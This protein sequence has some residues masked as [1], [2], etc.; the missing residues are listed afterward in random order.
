MDDF[1]FRDALTGTDIEFDYSSGGITIC[2]NP[3]V[4]EQYESIFFPGCSFINYAMPLVS[5]VYKTLTDN[6]LV[7][8]ISVLCCGKILSYEENGTVKRDAFE[9]ELKEHIHKAGI[10]RIVCACPNC[11]KAMREAF[12]LDPRTKDVELAILPTVM[13]DCGYKVDSAITN[14]LM[15]GDESKMTRLCIHDSC[16]DR[17]Y[18]QFADGLRGILPK[19]IWVDPPHSRKR[20]IC[21][22]SLPRAQ[23]KIEQADKCANING[24]EAL[25]LNADA[26]VTA[27]MSCTFQ[28][29]MAQNKV[30]AVHFLELLYD[31]RIDWSTVGAWMKLRFLFD[32]H[33]GVNDITD[34]ARAFVS[35]G[36][37]DASCEVIDGLGKAID[38]NS[39]ILPENE[40]VSFSNDN[41]QTISE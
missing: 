5:A 21:C 32:E 27:C 29:N 33:L 11:V 17:E 39:A 20:S 4:T 13:T 3:D 41:V 1:K 19:D 22:G 9:E 30:P 15:K 7:D 24:T 37:S 35:I 23:G 6:D 36:E 16:P 25:E 34:S 26:L 28:L 2:R 10:K 14:R 8:G 38:E 18:G 12:S 40:D 31:W